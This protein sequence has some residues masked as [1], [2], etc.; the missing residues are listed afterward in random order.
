MDF[1]L[2]FTNEFALLLDSFNFEIELLSLVLIF[3]VAIKKNQM[4]S[5]VIA[6]VVSLIVGIY[7]LVISP[8]LLEWGSQSPEYKHQIRF[9]WYMGFVHADLMA[10]YVIRKTNDML[11]VRAGDICKLILLMFIA[12]LSVTSV[13]YIERLIFDTHH[14][15]M[16][17]KSSIT[18][19]NTVSTVTVFIISFVFIIAMLTPEKLRNGIRGFSDRKLQFFPISFITNKKWSL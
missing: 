6:I 9:L 15:E 16:M 7:S 10:I 14:L 4:N 1:S 17:Y 8:K 2:M 18:S 19:I 12:R 5:S 13:R 3:F 11:Q